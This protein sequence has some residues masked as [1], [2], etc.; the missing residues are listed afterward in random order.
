MVKLGWSDNF[1]LKFKKSWGDYPN[2][3]SWV[4]HLYQDKMFPTRAE[5]NKAYDENDH[6]LRRGGQEV[7]LTREDLAQF[8]SEIEDGEFE[9]DYTELVGKMKALF[10]CEKIVFFY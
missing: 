3:E 7:I 8:E 10:E 6:R 9:V 2:L 5:F 1:D 4:T